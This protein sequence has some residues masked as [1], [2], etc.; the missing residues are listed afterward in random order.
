[1]YRLHFDYIPITI[2]VNKS[3]PQSKSL[4]TKLFNFFIQIK[5]G[6]CQ[7]S[8]RKTFHQPKEPKF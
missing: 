4:T 2:L 5:N 1:M 6:A 7:A 3:Y 8:E